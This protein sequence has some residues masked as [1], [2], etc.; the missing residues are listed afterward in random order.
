M[1]ELFRKRDSRRLVGYSTDMH[2]RAMRHQ[3]GQTTETDE[4]RTIA[5][6]LERSVA[7]AAENLAT[8]KGMSVSEWLCN[9][10]V[11]ATQERRRE[12]RNVRISRPLA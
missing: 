11:S 1:N 8:A 6:R 5:C 4:S 12:P 3:P 7:E 9:L 10:I 2:Q